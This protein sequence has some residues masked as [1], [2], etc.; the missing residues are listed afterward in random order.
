MTNPKSDFPLRIGLLLVVLS[1]F[2]YL[3]YDE[4]MGIFNRH[5]TLPLVNEDIVAVIGLGFAVAASAIAVLI[6]LYY[7][8]GRE[9]SKP[10]LIMAIRMILF[11]VALY[12][13]LGFLPSLF[14]EGP[15]TAH[16]TIKRFFESTLPTLTDAVA[17]PVVLGRLF[18]A[19]NPNKPTKEALKW[20]LIAGTVYLFAFWINNASEWI[21]AVIAKGISYIS[22]YPVNLFSFILTTVG[23]LALSLYSAYFSKKT[24]GQ[25]TLTRFDQKKAGLILTGI[26]MY[27]TLTLLLWFIFGS[28]G[29]WGTW[30]AWLLGHGYLDVWG[31]TLPFIGLPLLF[32]AGGSSETPTSKPSKGLIHNLKRNQLNLFLFITE[33]L[34][35]IFYGIFSSAYYFTIPSTK[36]DIGVP[37]YHSLISIFGLL[38]FIAV[39]LV[40]LLSTITKTED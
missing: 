19:L 5:I 13:V 18:F 34:G 7:V 30:Y 17:I 23:M 38:Y 8:V 2:F 26:G 24:F 3:L 39:T 6:V 11:L 20:G 33:G 25:D 40:L 1:W 12:F 14:V 9:L 16:Y 22:Q 15:G 10:E 29:G 4:T 32:Y 35:I 36:V 31:L 37:S 28:V 21:G 27:L